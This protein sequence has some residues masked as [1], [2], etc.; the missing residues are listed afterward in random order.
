MSSY[1]RFKLSR[2]EPEYQSEEPCS[3]S[4]YEVRV[5][6]A[7]GRDM[8][9]KQCIDCGRM[10]G[11]WLKRTALTSIDL[12]AWDEDIHQRNWQ[13]KSSRREQKR[14]DNNRAWFR[15][16]DQYLSSQEWLDKRADVLDRDEFK[17]QG[18]MESEAKN[19]H[20]LSYENV[21]DEFCFELISLCEECHG[22]LHE[23]RR[24]LDNSPQTS[25][26]ESSSQG[27]A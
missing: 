16:Y 6:H 8:Y 22:R 7:K 21:G 20:H 1:W 26:D 2:Q 3:C 24:S 9:A 25:S 27:T 18:C 12:P 10:V 23:H 15:T 14:E 5:K 19:V 11:S 13:E 17:C 4:N